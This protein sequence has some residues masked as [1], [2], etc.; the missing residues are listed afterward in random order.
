MKIYVL[1]KWSVMFITTDFS[2]LYHSHITN[3][4]K[5]IQY[6]MQLN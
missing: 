6:N 3:N 2:Y 4:K 1:L 5:V